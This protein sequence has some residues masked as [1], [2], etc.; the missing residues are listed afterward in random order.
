MPALAR[1]G[2]SSTPSTASDLDASFIIVDPDNKPMQ[3]H[4]L[5][6]VEDTL[7]SLQTTNS[8]QTQSH[9]SLSAG[10]RPG[11]STSYAHHWTSHIKPHGRYFVDEF[12]RVCIPR[13]INLSGNCKM[14]VFHFHRWLRVPDP[15]ESPLCTRPINHDH[16]TFPH[17]HEEVTFTG[18]PF[19]LE[20]ADAHFAR[21]R[22]WG[23]TFS[24]RPPGQRSFHVRPSPFLLQ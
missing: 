15:A 4:R 18:R 22:R 2:M 6:Q 17:G 24:T 12:E 23:L 13:G 16:D 11:S 3:Q 8:Q 9:P 19:P 14:C 21:L 10:Y 1:I 7:P 20:D 5:P